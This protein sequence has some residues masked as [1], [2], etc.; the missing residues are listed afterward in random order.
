MPKCFTDENS[1]NSLAFCITTNGFP[2]SGIQKTS[3]ANKSLG[4][5]S[6]LKPLSHFYMVSDE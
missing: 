6:G 3:V 5:F 2:G 4:R 1:L